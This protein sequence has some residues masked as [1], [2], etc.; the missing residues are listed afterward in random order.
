MTKIQVGLFGYSTKGDSLFCQVCGP[1]EQEGEVVD[2]TTMVRFTSQDEAEMIM[3]FVET[4]RTPHLEAADHPKVLKMPA[5]TF[6]DVNHPLTSKDIMLGEEL[7]MLLQTEK[8]FLVR[9]YSHILNNPTNKQEK[10]HD[11]ESSAEDS[12]TDP[13]KQWLS[14]QIRAVVLIPSKR[15]P[16]AVDSD[17]EEKSYYFQWNHRVFMD[18]SSTIINLLDRLRARRCR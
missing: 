6:D 9:K 8:R 16:A 14:S 13:K 5:L 18:S 10:Q 1:A 11:D 15:R 7:D 17:G 2:R 3:R 4:F 12:D